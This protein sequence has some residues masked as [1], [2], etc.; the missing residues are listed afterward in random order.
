MIRSGGEAEGG[1][2]ALHSPEA[3][4]HEISLR[5]LTLESCQGAVGSVLIESSTCCVWLIPSRVA[6][7]SS[8]ATA[9][10]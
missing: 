9:S 1:E 7:A 2:Y 8:I 3:Y 4:V 10:S 6:P 5:S